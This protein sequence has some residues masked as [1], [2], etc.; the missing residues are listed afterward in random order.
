MVKLTV[1]GS[2]IEIPVYVLPGQADYSIALAF[3]QFGEMRIAHVPDGGGTNVFPVRKSNAMHTV[4]G[5]TLEKTGRRADL[6]M[7]QEHGVIPEGR[8]IVVE[9]EYARVLKHDRARAR[10]RATDAS[11]GLRRTA[12]K[13]GIPPDGHITEEDLKKGFQGGYG[14]KQQPPAPVDR[15]AGALPARPRAARVARQPVPVGHG[16]R[17]LAPAPAARRAPSRAR[18]RTTSRSSASTR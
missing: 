2:T 1:N 13:I 9:I 12:P 18:R 4:A 5:C 15:E 14:N 10:A 8:E 17:P 16:H 11:L 3:G 6:V 7:T